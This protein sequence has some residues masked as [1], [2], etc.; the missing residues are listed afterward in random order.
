MHVKLKHNA[1][2][3]IKDCKV[4]FSWTTF[5]FGFWVCVFRQDWKHM[6]IQIGAAILTF[7]L[8]WLVFPFICNKMY[9]RSLLEKGYVPASDE[10]KSVL[11]AKGIM[12]N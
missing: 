8:S 10:D 3:L 7:G 11:V 12:F 4:G 1:T 5:F 6:L 9:I 2:G